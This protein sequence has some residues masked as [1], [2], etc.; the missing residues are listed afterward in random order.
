MNIYVPANA[1]EDSPIILQVNN[2]GWMPSAGEGYNHER[3]NVH[4]HY[5]QTRARR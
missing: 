4:Q 3:R 1:T 5:Q 2:S